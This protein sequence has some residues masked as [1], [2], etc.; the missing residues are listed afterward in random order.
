[1]R[2][3]Y[4]DAGLRQLL[5]DAEL[6]LERVALSVASGDAYFTRHYAD[7]VSPVY[8]RRK[9]PLDDLIALCEG[10][11]SALPGVLTPDELLSAGVA[12]DEAVAV[13]KWHRRLAG[14]ARRKNAFLQF[15]YKGA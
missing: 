3:R 10:L 14:D 9:I 4:D 8:R 5:R 7:M 1:M 13:F 15:L 6:L 12:L 11:R 2:E